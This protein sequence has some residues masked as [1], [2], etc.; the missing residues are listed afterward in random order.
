MKIGWCDFCLRVNDARISG[1]F[2]E[3]LGFVRVEGDDSE[4][5]AV[6]VNGESRIGLFQPEFMST[7]ISLNFRGGDVEEVCDHLVKQGVEFTKPCR[8]GKSGGA[9]AELLDPD[10][11]LI[12]LDC[13]PGETK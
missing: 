1:E 9:S 13:A 4:G 12:F 6:M 2:Y 5:W 8:V 11:H 7:P 3:K 10:G